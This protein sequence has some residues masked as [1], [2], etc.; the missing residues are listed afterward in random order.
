MRT[1]GCALILS[2]AALAG[3]GA[4]QIKGEF[5]SREEL[6][7]IASTPP[8]AKLDVDK[9]VEVA[10]WTLTGPLPEALDESVDDAATPWSRA[11]VAEANKHP[12]AV[13]A[14]K[15]MACASRELAAYY[16]ARTS[17]P[18][19]ALFRFIAGRCGLPTSHMSTSFVTLRAPKSKSDEEVFA[20]MQAQVARGFGLIPPGQAYLGVGFVRDAEHAVVAVAGARRLARVEP[21]AL[22]RNDDSVVFKG[23]VLSPAGTMSALATAGKYGFRACKPNAAVK[24]PAFEVQCPITKDDPFTSIEL[25]SV[26]AGR[27]LGEIALEATVFSAAPT[28]EFKGST[29]EDKAF[30]GDKSAVARAVAE[31]VNA[32]RSKAG[33]PS[34]AVSPAQSVV[35]DTLAPYYFGAVGGDLDAKIADKVVLGMMAGWEVGGDIQQGHF[36][37]GV[38]GQRDPSRL[39]DELAAS[40]FGRETL[41]DPR[42]SAVAVGVVSPEN[43]AL[44]A[45]IGTYS[46]L[47]SDTDGE[48]RKVM[49]ALAKRRTANKLPPPD[50]ISDLTEYAKHAAERVAKED[51]EPSEALKDMLQQSAEKMRGYSMQGFAL[52]ASK[53]EDLPFP[54]ELLTAPDLPIAVGVAHYRKPGSPWSQLVV[55]VV[56]ATRPQQVAAARGLHLESARAVTNVTKAGS[57]L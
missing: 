41:F 50:A 46:M 48:V 21:T 17:R 51:A 31:R 42:A 9:E 3:C 12:G 2:S 54:P 24:L 14:T 44:G 34:L 1:I 49:E 23:E 10:S 38:Y 45:V 15:G 43:G 29:A 30:A 35:A 18:P 5:P 47:D 25:L 32:I 37:S 16:L 19:H 26:P 55:F 4:R 33:F 52:T 57:K 56:V 13:L 22:I 39:V 28:L 8:P 6:S 36:S 20:A 11:A 7:A 53:A 40:P 27:L